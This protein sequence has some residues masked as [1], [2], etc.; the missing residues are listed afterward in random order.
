[1]TNIKIKGQITLLHMLMSRFTI[2][3]PCIIVTHFLL[4][5][6]LR[7]IGNYYL[8]E[9]KHLMKFP[10]S[11]F[12][13]FWIMFPETYK[14]RPWWF[15]RG[16]REGRGSPCKIQISLK[17]QYKITKNMPRTPLAK[18]NYRLE[19]YSGSAHVL[20]EALGFDSTWARKNKGGGGVEMI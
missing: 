12:K 14:T 15:M 8:V 5:V 11:D 13:L 10:K 3:R 9:Y 20:L 16:S 18:S 17:L 7:R 19:K 1:M 2:F 4:F 6:Y